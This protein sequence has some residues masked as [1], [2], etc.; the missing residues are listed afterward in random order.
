METL[1]LVF[2]LLLLVGAGV[3][4]VLRARRIREQALAREA[5]ALDALLAAEH[6]RTPPSVG[7][8]VDTSEL[9]T[10]MPPA[11]APALRRFA[12]PAPP[13]EGQISQILTDDKQLPPLR[14]A[15]RAQSA[16]GDPATLAAGVPLRALVLTWFEA[17]GYRLAPVPAT[18]WPIEGVLVHGDNA[19]RSYAFVVQPERVSADRITA[20]LGQAAELQLHR[21]A[22][23]AESGAEPGVREGARRRH[24]RLIDRP[25]ML[26][27]LAEL[28]RETAQRIV[29]AARS[30][31]DR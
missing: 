9:R 23:V 1:I 27:E 5:A 20:L 2:L 13:E 15:T 4:F 18:A 29:A 19:A 12:V 28:P 8:V 6:T 22:L 7:E 21:V 17:R 25:V 24:V 10:V 14:S 30:R 26:A 31:G 16:P 3:W 11:P